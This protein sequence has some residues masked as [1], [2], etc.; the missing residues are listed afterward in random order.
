LRGWLGSVLNRKGYHIDA[1]SLIMQTV[2]ADGNEVAGESGEIVCTSLFNYAMPLIRY[3]VGDFG[4]LSDEECPCGRVL[5]LLSRIEGRSDSVIL[6][7]GGRALSPRAVT[8]AMGSF[9]LN[10]VIEQFRFLQET[11]DRIK[12]F[13]KLQDS[14]VDN[15]WVGSC[16]YFNMFEL[17]EIQTFTLVFVDDIF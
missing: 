15:R 1:D 3:K 8:V 7:P 4:V 14:S 11:K 9:L 16:G 17:K 13:L 12:I 5:P 2:D 10:S 6:L